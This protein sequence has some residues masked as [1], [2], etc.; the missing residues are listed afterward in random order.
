MDDEDKRAILTRRARWIA[1]ALTGMAGPACAPS[2][3]ATTAVV[4]VEAPPTA[5]PA[6]AGASASSPAPSADQ[7][8]DGVPD[9]LDKCPGVPGPENPGLGLRGCPAP[10]LSIR[11]SVQIPERVTFDRD[12]AV[13][14]PK[15]GP[16]LE[17][18]AKAVRDHPELRFS[19]DGHTSQDEPEALAFLR[20]KAVLDALV[21]RGAPAH[22]L[23]AKSF[24]ASRPRGGLVA[25]A[26]QADNRRVE[27]TVLEDPAAR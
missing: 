20:A 23:E 17:Q 21:K 13:L 9:E 11:R 4:E 14:S 5:P 24:G 18:I 1:A 19:V 25:G 7:D 12:E 22:R 2:A 8:A 6:S 10:C 27:L 16:V 15:H 26:S 3:P